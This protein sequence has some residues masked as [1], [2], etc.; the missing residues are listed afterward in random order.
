MDDCKHHHPHCNVRDKTPWLPTRLLDLETLEDLSEVRICV[1]SEETFTVIP[2][3][4]TLSHRWLVNNDT[5]LKLTNDNIV[6]LKKNVSIVEVSKTFRDAMQISKQLGVRYLWIDSLCIVQGD[7]D[8][9][10]QEAALIVKVYKNGVINISATAAAAVH[11]TEGCFRDREGF[12]QPFRTTKPASSESPEELHVVIPNMIWRRNIEMADIQKRGWV[13]QERVLS[14]RVLHYAIEQVFWECRQF[15]ACESVPFGIE[16]GFYS[17]GIGNSYIKDFVPGLALEDYGHDRDQMERTFWKRIVE[18]FSAYE[19]T[20]VTD[21]LMALSRIASEVRCMIRAEYLAGLWKS[22]LPHTLL[23]V[24]KAGPSR[25]KRL[26]GIAPSW[27]WASISGPP[28]GI[29][30]APCGIQRQ[31]AIQSGSDRDSRGQNNSHQ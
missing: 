17:L 1:T 30:R 11:R 18:D 3:Y 7:N 9:W 2:E 25:P 12:L 6:Q 10:K 19:L 20:F 23:W 31:R 16:P 27:S 15:C 4:T 22:Q 26:S 29:S 24:A 21:K 14:P 13:L 8:D 28:C 5:Q